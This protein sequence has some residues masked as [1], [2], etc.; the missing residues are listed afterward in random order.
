MH[1]FSLMQQR[2]N[3]RLGSISFAIIIKSLQTLPLVILKPILN[4]LLKRP[5]ELM[6][7]LF[8]LLAAEQMLDEI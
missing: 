6:A 5:L 2:T 3:A 8:H 7:T 4:R 1:C